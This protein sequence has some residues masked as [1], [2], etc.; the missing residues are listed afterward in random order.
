MSKLLFS[1]S[2]CL[3]HEELQLIA[4]S[5]TKEK[6]FL[7]ILL[8][9]VPLY[10]CYFKSTENFCKASG[11]Q[12][13]V[14]NLGEN[15][16]EIGGEGCISLRRVPPWY[17]SEYQV[18]S[19]GDS[20]LSAGVT[21]FSSK[22]GSQN[23][24]L[25]LTTEN[26]GLVPEGIRESFR[27]LGISHLLVPSGLHLALIA[28]M[29]RLVRLRGWGIVTVCGLYTLMIGYRLP[30]V[31]AFMFLLFYTYGCR[32]HWRVKFSS[33]LLYFVLAL[34]MCDLGALT[35]V[36]LHMTVFALIGIHV[37]ISLWRS[38]PKLIKLI[39]VPFA[40]WV[41]TSI[42]SVLVF[43]TFVPLGWLWNLILCVMFGPLVLLPAVVS[44]AFWHFGCFKTA[45]VVSEFLDLFGLF[46]GTLT[47][48]STLVSTDLFQPFIIVSYLLLFVAD[49]R[50][51]DRI[52]HLI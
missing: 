42:L 31:R 2:E 33:S 19:L 35:S 32:K 1:K 18:A 10:H 40:I 5:N 30:V 7:G 50:E 16:L 41:Y 11:G 44:S 17:S 48:H 9:V 13:L 28:G 51:R 15:R 43:G 49:F 37:G 39:L 14:R 24:A 12:V 3:E 47:K 23:F 22:S 34:A 25:A 29:C 26:R 36:S 52:E 27:E 8:A 45:E 4:T 6:I 38:G 46:V 20:F 21:N